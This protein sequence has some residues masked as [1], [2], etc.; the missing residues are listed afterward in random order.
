M[1]GAPGLADFAGDWRL[2]RQ[3]AD[4]RG[5]GGRFKGVARFIPA[6]GGLIYREEGLLRIGDAAPMRAVRGY[7]W[8]AEAGRIVVEHADGAAFHA[9]DP[10]RPEA[11]HDCPPD[12]YHVAYDFSVW[13]DWRATWTVSGP[14]KDYRMVSRYCRPDR[15]A[16]PD[17]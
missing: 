5:P 7:L 11:V 14:A 2:D 8:R 16:G 15:P 6:A 17:G 13:P 12:R 3:I 10:A 4:R 1:T 9:F